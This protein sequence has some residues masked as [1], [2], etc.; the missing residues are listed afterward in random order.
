[1]VA[2]VQLP[3]KFIH[4][5]RISERLLIVNSEYKP[6]DANGYPDGNRSKRFNG[7]WCCS[8]WGDSKPR[9]CY[10]SGKSL[11]SEKGSAKESII[12]KLSGSQ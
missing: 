6:L 9:R 10:F 2:V 11:A 5:K 4:E 12:L 1:M 7:S 8:T 3:S